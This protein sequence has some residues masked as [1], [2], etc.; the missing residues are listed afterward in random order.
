MKTLLETVIGKIAQFEVKVDR[1]SVIKVL[2]IVP[3]KFSCCLV[4]L[5]F[6][7]LELLGAH[8]V[9]IG[10]TFKYTICKIQFSPHDIVK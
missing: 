10:Y 8:R 2:T 7:C 5:M 4:F 9:G 1:F 6:T 3:C